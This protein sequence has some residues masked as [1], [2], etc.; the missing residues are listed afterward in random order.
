MFVLTTFMAQVRQDNPRYER[1]TSSSLHNLVTLLSRTVPPFTAAEVATELKTILRTD[2]TKLTIRYAR[3]YAYLLREIP[4][5]I[6]AMRGDIFNFRT[7]NL[8]RGPNGSIVHRLVW[9]SDTGSLGDL[10]HIRVREHVSWPTPTAPVVPTTHIIAP[11]QFNNYRIA[12]FHAGVGNAV[13]TPGT[14]G[15]GNDTHAA[16]GPFTPA[17]LTYTGAAPL[18]VTFTQ[19]YQASY[20]GGANWIDIPN[21]RYTIRRELRQVRNR[22]HVTLT[23]TNA[24]V[25]RDALS[26]TLIL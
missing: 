24:T 7:G 13:F 9:D 8:S 19:V 1:R 5:L 4:G 17:A 6:A 3:S 20:D 12:G 16:I 23:K 26:N 15:N 22:A 18:V 14:A 10:A 11:D 25:P 21:S 2:R